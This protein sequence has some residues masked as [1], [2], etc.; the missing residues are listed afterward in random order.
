MVDGYIDMGEK[1]LVIVAN[2]QVDLLKIFPRY[3]SLNTRSGVLDTFQQITIFG[4]L[5]EA[6]K[7][8]CEL[9]IQFPNHDW[10]RMFFQML[11][12]EIYKD[13]EHKVVY[14]FDQIE[15]FNTAPMFEISKQNVI[16]GR[17]S[18][19][20]EILR[21]PILDWTLLVRDDLKNKLERREDEL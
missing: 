15:G 4:L 19:K 9:S 13:C 5:D 17:V 10:L 6:N 1:Y 12:L 21:V 18:K 11:T 16:N 20:E 14:K 8:H 7:E 3:F 2:K